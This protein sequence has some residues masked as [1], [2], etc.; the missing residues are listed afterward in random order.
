[1]YQ[2]VL[3]ISHPSVDG[4]RFCGVLA[5]RF[6][7]V[8]Q[9][10]KHFNT[11]IQKGAVPWIPGCVEHTNAMSKEIKGAKHNQEG[12]AVLWLDLVNVYGAIA[13]K[14]VGLE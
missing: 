14:L 2:A 5:S 13:N 6:T 4:K 10:N 9:I 8:L 3:H 7:D 1:M 12:L 11:S